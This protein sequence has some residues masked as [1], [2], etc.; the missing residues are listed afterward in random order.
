M[1]LIANIELPISIDDTDFNQEKVDN[2]RK[3][4]YNRIKQELQTILNE[5]LEDEFDSVR[6]KQVKLEWNKKE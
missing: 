4:R 2:E 5:L 3:N 6:V 1:K